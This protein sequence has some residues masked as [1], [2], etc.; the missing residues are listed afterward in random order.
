MSP[1]RVSRRRLLIASGAF[2]AA[3]A[4]AALGWRTMFTSS[5]SAGDSLPSEPRDAGRRPANVLHG[6]IEKV[7]DASSA[8]LLSSFGESVT[9]VIENDASI[10]PPTKHPQVGDDV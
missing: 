2:I 7:I 9:L 10:Y 5:A 6:S 3:G 1:G 8:Q 4:S